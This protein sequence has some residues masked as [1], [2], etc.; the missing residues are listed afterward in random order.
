[1]ALCWKLCTHV[2]R[3]PTNCICNQ[4]LYST[5]FSPFLDQASDNT[6]C[7]MYGPL[8]FLQHQLVGASHQYRHSL[9]S[10][11]YTSDLSTQSQDQV[12][13]TLSQQE[14]PHSSHP[15]LVVCSSH[16]EYHCCIK[17]IIKDGLGHNKLIPWSISHITGTET[18]EV[19]PREDVA[20]LLPEN[21]VPKTQTSSSCPWT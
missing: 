5:A 15:T 14:H 9:P 21:P 11:G 13:I 4:C 17:R 18:S 8:C 7:I 2:W 1:M 12:F 16:S 19:P 6:E 3:I 10:I 20:R